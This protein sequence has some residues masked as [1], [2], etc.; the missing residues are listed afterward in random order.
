MAEGATI[1]SFAN[2]RGGDCSNA[3]GAG[4][5]YLWPLEHMPGEL[6]RTERALTY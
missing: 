4:G 2:A 6:S 3:V 1:N 5:V